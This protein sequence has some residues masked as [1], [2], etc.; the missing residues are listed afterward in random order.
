MAKDL[1]YECINFPVSKKDFS[2]VEQK[3][4]IC[5]NAFCYENNLTYLV[6]ASD[7]KIED[8]MDLLLISDENKS[9]YVVYQK[10]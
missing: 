10:F 2:K 4:I 5:I 8:H 6:Y 9:H 1:D 7:Q 3:N